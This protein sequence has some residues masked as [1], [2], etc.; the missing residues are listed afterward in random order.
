MRAKVSYAPYTAGPVVRE[1]AAWAPY[2]EAEGKPYA[3]YTAGPV[4]KEIYAPYDS[5]K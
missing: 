5:M 4:V 2:T 1:R 3:P